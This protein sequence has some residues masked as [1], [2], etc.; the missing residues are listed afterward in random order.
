L[1]HVFAAQGEASRASDRRPAL[2]YVVDRGAIT[3][4]EAIP[5]GVNDEIVMRSPAG[6]S[7][8]VGKDHVLNH[9]TVSGGDVKILVQR[10]RNR[11][12]PGLDPLCRIRVNQR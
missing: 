6:R 3:L 11:L 5:A 8:P 10:F 9:M 2:A 7:P 1:Q 12:L 4:R